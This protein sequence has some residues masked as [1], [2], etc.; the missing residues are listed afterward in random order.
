D[1]FRPGLRVTTMPSP[2]ALTLRSLRQAGYTADVVERFIA[3]V[4]IRRD[5]FH[6]IDV[7][8]VHRAEVGVLRVQTTTLGSLPARVKK[9]RQCPELHV[10]LAAGNAFEV[11]GWERRAERWHCKRVSVR[12][13][14]LEPVTIAA[15]ARRGRRAVQPGLFDTLGQESPSP[16]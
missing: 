7:V 2:T 10:W 15:I 13:A 1:G 16:P 4:N 11:H 12:G 8:G 3:A 5:L 9:A 6:C 14:D